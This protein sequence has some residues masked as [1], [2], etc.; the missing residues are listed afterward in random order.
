MPDRP[1]G[2][3]GPALPTLAK[4]NLST[5]APAGAVPD[6]AAQMLAPLC[7]AA[8]S[9]LGTIAMAMAIKAGYSAESA[10][11]L[12]YSEAEREAI[13]QLAP[14]ALAEWSIVIKYPAT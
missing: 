3:A 5:P 14:A 4:S 10:M 11:T 6:V 1:S 2:S 12:M 7:A 8:A 13:G 9:A